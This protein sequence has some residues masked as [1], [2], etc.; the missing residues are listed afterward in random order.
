[1]IKFGMGVRFGF[2]CSFLMLAASFAKAQ[3]LLTEGLLSYKITITSPSGS[4]ASG[5]FN[6]TV[7][8]PLL[9]R[10]LKMSNGYENVLLINTN[11]GTIYSMQKRGVRNYA[12]ELNLTEFLSKSNKY[13]G[14]TIIGEQKH[15]EKFAGLEAYL[16]FA[17]YQDGTDMPVSVSHEWALQEPF[18]FECFP[19][20]KF[21]PLNFSYK[22]EDGNSLKF[23]LDKLNAVPV[24]NS[25]FRIPADYKMVSYNEYKSSLK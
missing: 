8:G 1:M 11:A 20:A 16:G 2:I 5:L 25:V 15:K 13:R 12:V 22:D 6:I 23:E 17:H 7:K 14:A 18:V 3:K 24:E 4:Q 21:L 9:L 19:D 10:E